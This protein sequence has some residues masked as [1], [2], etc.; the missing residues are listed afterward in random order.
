M[1]CRTSAAA[2]A[3]CF[4]EARPCSSLHQHNRRVLIGGLHIAKYEEF[5]GNLVAMD[6]SR[7]YISRQQMFTP[8]SALFFIMC[9][10]CVFMPVQSRTD[11]MLTIL[12]ASCSV[13]AWLNCRCSS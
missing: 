13:S 12:W 9:K 5:V 7:S 2:G 3:Q 4:T 11:I 10:E 1:P 8:S 6:G